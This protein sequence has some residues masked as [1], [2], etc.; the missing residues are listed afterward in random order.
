[1]LIEQTVDQLPKF[2]TNFIHN[3]TGASKLSIQDKI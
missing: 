3:K 1:M 2:L